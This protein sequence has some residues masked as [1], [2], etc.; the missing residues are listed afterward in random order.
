MITYLRFIEALPTS[1]AVNSQSNRNCPILLPVNLTIDNPDG[2]DSVAGPCSAPPRCSVVP[3]G[4]IHIFNVAAQAVSAGRLTGRFFQFRQWGD[5][6]NISLRLGLLLLI[7]ILVS[8]FLAPSR[9]A[10]VPPNGC[11]LQT[12]SGLELWSGFQPLIFQNGGGEHV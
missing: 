11:P 2:S 5:T 1:I 6:M 7:I 8:I 9:V 3:D 4:I 10:P 12:V